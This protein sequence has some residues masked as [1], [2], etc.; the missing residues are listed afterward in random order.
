MSLHGIPKARLLLGIV[1]ASAIPADSAG[2]ATVL[3][4][5]DDLR[6]LHESLRWVGEVA[7]ML[8]CIAHH[9]LGD[10]LAASRHPLEVLSLLLLLDAIHDFRSHFLDVVEVIE[11]E[12]HFL[13][14]LT[15][16]LA[17]LLDE[18]RR[19]V[20]VYRLQGPLIVVLECTR[21]FLLL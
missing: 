3:A 21:E 2:V 18:S 15:A 12:V 16:V 20:A 14:E 6:D 1:L 17:R 9:R 4:L 5:S 13:V 10:S 11:C 19:C 7:E 8:I